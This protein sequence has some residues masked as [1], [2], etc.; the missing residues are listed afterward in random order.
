MIRSEFHIPQQ[1]CSINCTIP[2]SLHGNIA[3]LIYD[4]DIIQ[5]FVA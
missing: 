4:T 3:I 1:R 2:P 5:I